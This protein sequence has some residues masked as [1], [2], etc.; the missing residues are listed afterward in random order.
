MALQPIPELDMTGMNTDIELIEIDPEI[1]NATENWIILAHD[2]A[3]KKALI[4]D[5]DSSTMS[6]E[7]KTDT[8]KALTNL[9]ETY[10]TKFEDGGEKFIEIQV[11][12]DRSNQTKS[13]PIGHITR[14]SFDREKISQRAIDQNDSRMMK[15]GATRGIVL[16]ETENKTVRNI[17]QLREKKYL[18]NLKTSRSS[19]RS[20]SSPGDNGPSAMSFSGLSSS[21]GFPGDSS[22]RSS[23]G[24]EI[25]N[26][27]K[28]LMAWSGG[29]TGQS[30]PDDPYH[31]HNSYAYWA[32]KKAYFPLHVREEAAARASEP[33]QWAP[34]SFDDLN[35][36]VKSITH[37]W[38]PKFEYSV[39]GQAP[40]YTN[41]FT[42]DARDLIETCYP[43]DSCSYAQLQAFGEQFGYASHYLT[44]VGNPMH[45][46]REI[47]QIYDDQ[48]LGTAYTPHTKY[49]DFV[50]NNW[51]SYEG[52]VTD[53]NFYFPVS[54][55]AQATR[56]LATYSHA[57]LDTLY[58][59]VKNNPSFASDEN[60]D[61]ITINCIQASARYTRGLAVYCRD[62]Y[63]E[64]FP[65]AQFKYEELGD[66]SNLQI[67]YTDTSN[68]IGPVTSREWEFTGGS[69]ATSTDSQVTVTYPSRG[70]KLV[71]LTVYKDE[72]YEDT[73]TMNVPVGVTP[74]AEFSYSLDGRY[75][76][77]FTDKS[78]AHSDCNPVTYEWNFGD[79]SPIST[80]K[81]PTHTYVS[82]GEYPAKLLV[83]TTCGNA[84][85]PSDYPFPIY[86]PNPI[87]VDFLKAISGMNVALTD[88]SSITADSYNWDFGDNSSIS[89]DQ[90]PTHTYDKSGNYTIRLTAQDPNYHDYYTKEVIIT[91][92]SQS[93]PPLANF[94]A[95]PTS[96]P[97]PLTVQFNDTSTGSPTSWLWDFGDGNMTNVAEQNPV[98]TYLANGTYNVSLNVTNDGGSNTMTKVRFIRIGMQDTFGMFRDGY[99]YMDYNG[100][101]QWDAT[102]AGMI[103]PFG[104][105][106]DT[107]P[108]VGDWNGDGK[109]EFGIF[110][111]GYWYMDYNGNMQWD[112]TDASMIKPFG[113]TGDTHP[114]AG[115]WNGDG[116]DEFGIFRDGY[117]YMD[118]NGNMQWDAT[119]ASMIK[120]FGVPNDT[121]P[122]VG[123]WNGDGKDEFGIFRDGYWYMDYNG[124]MQWD[125]TDAGMI[126]PFGI[127][128]DTYPL[129]GDWNGDGKDEFGIFRDGYWYMDYNGNMQWDATDA[130]MIKPFG[131]PGDKYPV[132]GKWS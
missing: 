111:N 1:T 46:G 56:N 88:K 34:S 3:G 24:F 72:D 43:D 7:E 120:P 101:M 100:N 53:G 74:H 98:H 122:L 19:A 28:G 65:V 39:V 73:T 81:N 29:S 112:A 22:V 132:A 82:S 96:G 104:V 45:T 18:A 77:K 4:D 86:I 126:K 44:D 16:N 23:G 76:A 35:R 40:Y 48:T 8:K 107:Y 64:E 87:I 10:P 51:A 57:Y 84:E 129:V 60:V 67:R 127:P 109:D 119:D 66:E 6:A 91:V 83:K 94:T 32:M 79:S 62:G 50:T 114:L 90:N 55:P 33:D 108:V 125:A 59:R 95:T 102:D 37:Y 41:A 63:T 31:G 70:M 38:N 58:Y 99:W 92:P 78:S 85:Y 42:E 118:Y 54:S 36:V 20:G 124:N 49:E 25:D 30:L 89:T 113:L 13:I 130:G 97:A 131:L 12:S 26:S 80:E 52:L 17:T 75:T 105:P 117:W 68:L 106:N 121:Y 115:D 71:Q 69:P 9:W 47:D 116:K 128:N 15:L 5:I 110:R 11:Q 93:S 103:R 61:L 2:D 123:D 14:I 27:G 21:S